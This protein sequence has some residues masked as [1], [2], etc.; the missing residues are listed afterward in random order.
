MENE[1]ALRVSSCHTVGI[2]GSASIVVG[3]SDDHIE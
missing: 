2:I 3:L 1:L